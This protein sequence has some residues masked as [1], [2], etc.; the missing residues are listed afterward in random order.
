MSAE[1]ISLAEQE[2]E[3]MLIGIERAAHVK[4]IRSAGR[5]AEADLAELRLPR[6]RAALR[7]IKNLIKEGS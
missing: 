4:N 5:T 1:D 7:T 6:L 3:L 2:A